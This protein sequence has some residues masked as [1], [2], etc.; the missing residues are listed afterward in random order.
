MIINLDVSPAVPALAQVNRQLRSEVLSLYHNT[1]TF[2]IGL[3]L[4]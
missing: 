2:R 4:T 1:N 3:A